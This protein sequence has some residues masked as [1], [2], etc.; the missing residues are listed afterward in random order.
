LSGTSFQSI[1]IWI[2]DFAKKIIARQLKQLIL[3]AVL[4]MKAWSI[5]KTDKLADSDEHSSDIWP[6]GS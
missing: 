2:L 4:A 5:Y 3:A 6:I 1:D